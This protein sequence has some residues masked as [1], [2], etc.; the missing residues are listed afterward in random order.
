MTIAELLVEKLN[1]LP[2]EKQ[3]ELLAFADS[4]VQEVQVADQLSEPVK[5]DQSRSISSLGERLM[6]IRQ[7]AIENGMQPSTVEE[8]EREIAE[9]RDRHRD[10]WVEKGFEDLSGL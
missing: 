10:L 9:E 6:A 4:L 5:T 3:Q 7:Q 2:P 1:V 8:V